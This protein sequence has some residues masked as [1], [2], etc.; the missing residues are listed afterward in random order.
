MDMV[1]KKKK[2]GRKTHLAITSAFSANVSHSTE[3][4]CAHNEPSCE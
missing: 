3:K 4:L 1:K 2:D